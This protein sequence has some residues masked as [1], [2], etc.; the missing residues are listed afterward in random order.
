MPVYI[1]SVTYT[2]DSD[3]SFPIINCVKDSIGSFPHSIAI[4]SGQFLGSWWAR[5]LFEIIYGLGQ[6][7]ANCRWQIQ[8][9]LVRTLFQ[10]NSIR[11]FSFSAVTF[12]LS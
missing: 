7:S 12:L 5:I 4:H 9:F 2:I 3:E 6:L 1:F 11:Q 8:K 10:L